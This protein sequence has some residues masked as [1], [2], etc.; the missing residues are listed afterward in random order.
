M[1][2]SILL[3]SSSACR[4][5][6][7]FQYKENMNSSLCPN[8][9]I[10]SDRSGRLHS[11]FQLTPV[12]HHNLLKARSSQFPNNHNDSPEMQTVSTLASFYIHESCSSSSSPKTPFQFH[13]P[14]FTGNHVKMS[15]RRTFR[16]SGNASS[17]RN[18][19]MVRQTGP[20]VDDAWLVTLLPCRSSIH[21]QSKFS[22][23]YCCRLT[24]RS[25][26]Q[27]RTLMSNF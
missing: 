2:C 5:A 23:K 3:H 6:V 8:S 17:T 15:L 22:N 18:E 24:L 10:Q 1:L 13:S 7:K 12:H 21:G 20:R 4:T 27:G 14:T 19:R 26:S 25:D 16:N 11:V 9:Y